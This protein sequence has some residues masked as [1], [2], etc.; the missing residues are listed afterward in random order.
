MLRRCR[1]PA[2][3]L[4]LDCVLPCPSA[5]KSD[6]DGSTPRS[7]KVES[8]GPLPVAAA[9]IPALT[10]ALERDV[11]DGT[12]RGYAI[13]LTLDVEHRFHIQGLVDYIVQDM[14][15]DD[16]DARMDV[17][18]SPDLLDSYCSWR[19]R[20]LSTRPT[21]L[22]YRLAT[23]EGGKTPFVHLR[24]RVSTKRQHCAEDDETL[25]CLLPRAVCCPKSIPS[26]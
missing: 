21:A 17:P 12:G 9:L 10:R 14:E 2:R 4:F 8:G 3:D 13:A 11:S 24:H 19:T 15:Q 16:V 26:R 7:H 1:S 25:N 22:S 5:A 20:A 6:C 18:K 23:R